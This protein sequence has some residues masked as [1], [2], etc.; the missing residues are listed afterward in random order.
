VAR[1]ALAHPFAARLAG[2]GLGGDF[3]EDPPGM[4]E[5]PSSA[6]S[7]PPETPVPM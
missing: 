4:M 5:G 2:V 7:S 1:A 6:P 3:L